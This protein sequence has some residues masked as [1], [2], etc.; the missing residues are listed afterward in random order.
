MEKCEAKTAKGDAEKARS[1]AEK[2][3]HEAEKAIKK[4]AELQRVN[5]EKDAFDAE[6]ARSEFMKENMYGQKEDQDVSTG[7]IVLKDTIKEY[8]ETEPEVL[9]PLIKQWAGFHYWKT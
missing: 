1:D 5:V 6:K 4:R 2:G 8:I 9:R 3:L 7:N